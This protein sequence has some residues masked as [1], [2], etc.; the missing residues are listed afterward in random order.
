MRDTGKINA[1]DKIMIETQKKR[2][3]R[4]QINFYINIHLVVGMEF[5]ACWV[6]LMPEGTRASFTVCDAYR[7]F[8]GQA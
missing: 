3:Y 8:V 1:Y 6:E 4:N 7:H 2:K 5:T